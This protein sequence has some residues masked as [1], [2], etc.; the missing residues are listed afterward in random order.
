MVPKFME[1]PNRFLECRDGTDIA[2]IKKGG[3]LRARP[4]AWCY[5]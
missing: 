5:N 3:R 4:L 2:A 1:A